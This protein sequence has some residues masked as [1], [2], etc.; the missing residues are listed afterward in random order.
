MYFLEA[1]LPLETLFWA[2]L[3]P[4]QA[5]AR[6]LARR[7]PQ[8]ISASPTTAA[9]RRSASLTVLVIS[10]VLALQVTLFLGRH[11]SLSTTVQPTTA[12]A[13]KSV[14]MTDQGFHTVPVI[15]A[16][17]IYTQV[18][19]FGLPAI[20]RAAQVSSLALKPTAPVAVA[21]LAERP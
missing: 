18:G 9:A 21:P 14:F 13:V 15:R 2:Q 10:T 5:P 6:L 3:S 17:F 7:Q 19:L 20:H 8:L 11:A 16:A 12:V 1:E 4:Q